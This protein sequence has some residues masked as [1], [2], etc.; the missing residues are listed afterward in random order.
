MAQKSDAFAK[1]IC[2]SVGIDPSLVGEIDIFICPGDVVRMVLNVL[3]G[4]DTLSIVEENIKD[5]L[6]HVT[7]HYE[8]K[9]G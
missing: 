2:K 5:N 9:D 4:S 7:L 1:L 6:K 8:G 3:P